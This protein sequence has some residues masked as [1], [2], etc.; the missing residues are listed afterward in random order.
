MFFSAHPLPNCQGRLRDALPP[1]G[2]S[3]HVCA[4]YVLASSPHSPLRLSLFISMRHG[5]END[6]NSLAVIPIPTYYGSLPSETGH[7]QRCLCARQN[8]PHPFLQVER[9][10]LR[11][12]YAKSGRVI[13]VGDQRLAEGLA[14]S[15]IRAL[16]GA[17]SFG[18][19]EAFI[20][21]AACRRP[22]STVPPASSWRFRIIR[23]C[24]TLST[25]QTRPV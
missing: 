25:R 12:P 5:H 9:K 22:N 13:G 8:G 10:L 18:R 7:N 4:R 20:R 1:S 2:W 19:Q 15:R 3:V 16:L 6:S 14:C 24:H 21:D 11:T 17:S 23:H